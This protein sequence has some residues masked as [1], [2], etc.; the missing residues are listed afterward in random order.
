[1]GLIDRLT[2]LIAWWVLVRLSGSPNIVIAT[3]SR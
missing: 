2:D 1:M 3:L